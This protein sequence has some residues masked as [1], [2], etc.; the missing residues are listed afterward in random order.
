LETFDMESP[1]VRLPIYILTD[2]A[3][4]QSF[5]FAAKFDQTFQIRSLETWNPDT[6]EY[7]GGKK[8]GGCHFVGEIPTAN[9]YQLLRQLCLLGTRVLPMKADLHQA[10]QQKG[11]RANSTR[12]F[13]ISLAESASPRGTLKWFSPATSM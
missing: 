11:Q 2:C 12:R 10:C 3:M 1:L 13:V 7:A 4:Q 5:R 8:G 9:R 6:E